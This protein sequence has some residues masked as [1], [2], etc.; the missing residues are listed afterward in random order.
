MAKISAPAA[1]A[2]AIAAWPTPP[3]AEWINTLSP[4]RDP[5]QI[6]QAVPGGGVRGGHR[7]RLLVGQARRQRDGQAGV[8]R[9][10]RSPAA[11]GEKPPTW[12]PTW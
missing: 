7:G 12:S 11:V 5:G 10:E 2:M 1:R 3:V 8:A 4:A 9:D 6:V